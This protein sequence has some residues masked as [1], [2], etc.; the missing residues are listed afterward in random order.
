MQGI[1]R[2][3]DPIRRMYIF[4]PL[5]RTFNVDEPRQ[6]IVSHEYKQPVEVPI[7]EYVHKNNYNHKLCNLIQNTP[8]DFSPSS[9]E[10]KIIK[11][12]ELLWPL[13]QTKYITR[14][15]A[16]L[17]TSSDAI[18][19]IFPIGFLPTMTLSKNEELFLTNKFQTN[20]TNHFL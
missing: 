4:F 8:H 17:L 11:A 20:I 9:E 10:Q 15:L 2:N 16:K 6:Q 19:K 5:T 12:L 1:I 13:L 14:L 18:H 3:Y 7:L